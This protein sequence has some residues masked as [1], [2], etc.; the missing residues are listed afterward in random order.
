MVV[1]GLHTVS[2]KVVPMYRW[3]TITHNAGPRPVRIAHAFS[4]FRNRPGN[5]VQLSMCNQQFTPADFARGGGNF[6]GR[7][8]ACVTAVSPYVGP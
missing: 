3:R 5:P 1:G 8:F 4:R 6:A 7:C 2:G